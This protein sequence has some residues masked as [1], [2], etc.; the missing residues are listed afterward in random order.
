MSYK[1]YTNIGEEKLVELL[2]ECLGE[3]EIVYPEKNCDATYYGYKIYLEAIKIYFK[4][5][6]LSIKNCNWLNNELVTLDEFIKFMIQ[7]NDSSKT[8]GLYHIYIDFLNVLF[9]VPDNKSNSISGL[10]YI[11]I[12]GDLPK[13]I[14]ELITPKR[15]EFKYLWWIRK[16]IKTHPFLGKYEKELGITYQEAIIKTDNKFYDMLFSKVDVVIELQEHKENHK[17]NPN[18]LTKEA[19]VRMRGKR[20]IYFHMIAYKKYKSIY[21]KDFFEKQLE[22]ALIEGLVYNYKNNKNIIADL[23]Q[24]EFNKIQKIKLLNLENEINLYQKESLNEL[25]NNKQHEI[26]LNE[27]NSVKLLY[28]TNIIKNILEWYL[29]SHKKTSVYNIDYTDVNF[30]EIFRYFNFQ[31]NENLDNFLEL[32]FIKKYCGVLDQNN[33][34]SFRKNISLVNKDILRF[35]WEG[36]LNIFLN[37]NDNEEIIKLLYPESD[38]FLEAKYLLNLLIT[39]KNIYE[40]KII[41]YMFKHAEE[42]I[43]SCDEFQKLIEEHITQKMKNEYDRK[44]KNLNT[45]L[46][47][48]EK[49]GLLL[50]KI[51]N[52]TI[53]SVETHIKYVQNIF[54]NNIGV[55]LKSSKKVMDYIDTINKNYTELNCL[56]GKT[57]KKKVLSP[58]TKEKN[59]SIIK[60]LDNFGINFTGDNEDVITYEDFKAYCD[61]KNITPSLINN[62][63]KL[64]N[65]DNSS[66]SDFVERVIFTD[67]ELST[68][69]LDNFDI[70]YIYDEETVKDLIIENTFD[71]SVNDIIEQMTSNFIITDDS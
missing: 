15:D 43:I 51:C 30:R 5:D 20:I 16:N 18:D 35:S 1:R 70:S 40:E 71:L 2:K 47:V 32:C 9:E 25:I 62:L 4:Y 69:K 36:L 67:Q 68:N 14:Q 42:K 6:E 8:M 13:N 21:L 19:M 55:S 23:V 11:P 45:N 66:N 27:I 12:Y 3:K 59:K 10:Y 41:N 37:P 61:T 58:N 54:T 46:S 17:K 33:I 56:L 24:Y 29:S 60:E 50:E 63:I 39:V 44:I 22:P 52:K 38:Y 28:D 65:D 49:K 34:T 26:I 64:L 57:N 48:A 7:S 53:K 31:D